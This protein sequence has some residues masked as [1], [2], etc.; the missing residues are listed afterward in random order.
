M[1]STDAGTNDDC[2]HC[3]QPLGNKSLAQHMATVCE[4]TEQ[5]KRSPP[6][7][8]EYPDVPALETAPDRVSLDERDLEERRE[9]AEQL[10]QDG[11]WV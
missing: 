1:S 5:P 3:G 10:T 7:V 8:E 11:D 9:L 4:M 2:I 6:R